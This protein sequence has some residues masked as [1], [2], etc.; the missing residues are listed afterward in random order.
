MKKLLLFL[1]LVLSGSLS[2]ITAMEKKSDKPDL[3][4]LTRKNPVNIPPQIKPLIQEQAV[5]NNR[6]NHKSNHKSKHEPN[7]EPNKRNK[8]S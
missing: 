4:R 1:I 2:Q 7:H 5:F 8:K 6:A 3:F